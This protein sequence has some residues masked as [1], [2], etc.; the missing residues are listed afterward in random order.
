MPTNRGRAVKFAEAWRRY[1]AFACLGREKE[2][3]GECANVLR[4][5]A[6]EGLPNWPPVWVRR[7]VLRE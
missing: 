4:V 1:F 2:H 7:T 3:A 5:A 6:I